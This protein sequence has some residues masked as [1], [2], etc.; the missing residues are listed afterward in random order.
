MDE[1]P[2]AIE[3]YS[4][5]AFR[6]IDGIQVGRAEGCDK[7]HKLQIRHSWMLDIK[8]LHIPDIIDRDHD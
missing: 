2:T 7:E 3:D 5:E 4:S 1:G 6:N 8:R